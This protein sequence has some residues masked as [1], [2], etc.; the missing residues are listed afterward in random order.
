MFSD[1]ERAEIIEHLAKAIRVL[2]T[3]PQRKAAFALNAIHAA[4][5]AIES[6]QDANSAAKALQ[7]LRGA[8]DGADIPLSVHDHTDDAFHV[9]GKRQREALQRLRTA[10]LRSATYYQNE[11][12]K[13]TLAAV[14]G[15]LD[16]TDPGGALEC[17]LS[18]QQIIRELNTPLGPRPTVKRDTATPGLRE[19]AGEMLPSDAVAALVAT[20][21]G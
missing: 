1:R 16:G 8:L 18:A 21:G 9:L 14:E 15:F 11:H 3:M 5:S 19:V 10:C 6:A 20:L 4:Q 13:W 12:L 2:R 7:T 17:A